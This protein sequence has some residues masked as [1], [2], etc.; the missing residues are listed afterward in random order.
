MGKIKKSFKNFTLEEDLAKEPVKKESRH[1]LKT[2]LKELID[3]QHWDEL[4]NETFE[5]QSR[6]YRRKR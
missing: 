1:N 3:N 6:N 4:E 5:E 2:H